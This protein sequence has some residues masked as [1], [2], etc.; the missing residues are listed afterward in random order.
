MAFQRSDHDDLFMPSLQQYEKLSLH[1]LKK[2]WLVQ[3]QIWIGFFGGPL[4]A[5][6][7]AFLNGRR[8]HLKRN[9]LVLI[10]L[11]GLAGFLLTLIT[12]V[13]LND[14][15]FSSEL[16][17]SESRR[18]RYIGRVYGIIAFLVLKQIQ[19]SGFRVYQFHN[20][21]IYGNLFNTGLAIVLFVG[22]IQNFLI[23]LITTL[24]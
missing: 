23:N 6:T 9:Q 19:K 5:A 16:L 2:P 1:Y 15:E 7:I 11:V 22:T 8:L 24:I 10:G 13:L 3:P 17:Q 12:A 18:I 14:I 20:D 4:A 21:G